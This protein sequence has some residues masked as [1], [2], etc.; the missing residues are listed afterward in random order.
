MA[1]VAENCTSIKKK[2]LQANPKRRFMCG[3]HSDLVAAQTLDS[4]DIS[5][6]QTWIK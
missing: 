5:M 1:P 3:N 2:V 6:E 4:F